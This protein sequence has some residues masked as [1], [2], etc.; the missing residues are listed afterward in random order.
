VV[1]NPIHGETAFGD[2]LLEGNTAF[3]ILAE[4]VARGG[5]SAAVL[6][7]QVLV[8]IVIVADRHFKQIG[9]G[10]ELGGVS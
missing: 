3:R 2:D 5:H 4:I 6:L 10:I 8:V 7:R 1:A 9:D